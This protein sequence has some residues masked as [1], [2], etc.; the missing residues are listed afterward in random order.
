MDAS[1][2]NRLSVAGNAYFSQNIGIGTTTPA[3]KLHLFD[4]ASG[5]IITLSG[6]TSNYRGITLKNTSNSENWF[7]GANSSNNFVIRRNGSV[8]DVTISS[9]GYVGIGNTNPQAKLDVYSNLAADPAFGDLRFVKENGWLIYLNEVYSSGYAYHSPQF[10]LRRARGSISTPSAVSNG[11]QIGG[12]F[13]R[14][15]D[16]SNFQQRAGISAWVSDSVSSGAVPMSLVFYTGSNSISERMRISHNGDITANGNVFVLS[17]LQVG[18]SSISSYNFRVLGTSY[19]DN[20]ID[21]SADIVAEKI[22]VNTVDPVY[23][24]NNK[25]FATYMSGMVGVKEETTGLI[26][27]KKN[28]NI[29]QGIIDFKQ[30]KEGSD[31]WLFYK[32]TNLENE[33]FK[34]LVILLTPNFDGKVWYEKDEKN[35]KIIIYA[36]SLNEGVKEVSYRLTAP[37]FDYKNWSN[38]ADKAHEGFEGLNLD[39]IL[40]KNE[41]KD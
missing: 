11:D 14:G 20:G 38:Y 40:K 19:F 41:Q 25:K 21:D 1:T 29:Y 16:G 31:L 12:F 3:T 26:V 33:G 39:K 17:K 4:S 35:K 7:Y 36:E 18:T 30:E 27:L 24:I 13:F 9:N 8:D 37:R 15:Y 10:I 28:K 5:P 6:L 34:N 32:V 22:D 23:T 2:I